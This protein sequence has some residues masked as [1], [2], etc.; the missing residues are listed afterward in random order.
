LRLL[1]VCGGGLAIGPLLLWPRGI[2]AWLRALWLRAVASPAAGGA[3][4]PCLG[5]GG[6]IPAR[7]ATRAISCGSCRGAAGGRRRLLPIT[8]GRLLARLL[9]VG[10]RRRLL[11][12]WLRGAQRARPCVTYICQSAQAIS[13]LS[14]TALRYPKA[15]QGDF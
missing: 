4:C 9:P 14:A 8:G 15:Q 12:V 6:A 1:P 3:I 5:G 10:S 13:V 11:A 7:A 2:A